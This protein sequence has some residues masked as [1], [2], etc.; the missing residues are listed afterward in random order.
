MIEGSFQAHGADLDR[1]GSKDGVGAGDHDQAY[2]FGRRP[3]SRAPFPFSER[4]FARML[5]LRS[6]IEAIANHA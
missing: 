5:I 2:H 3:T 4:E 6:R 1:A